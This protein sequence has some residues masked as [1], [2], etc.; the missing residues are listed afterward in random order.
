MLVEKM[1]LDDKKVYLKIDIAGAELE[2]IPDIIKYH[3]NLT[4]INLVIKYDNS[5]EIIK[6]EKLLREVEKNFILVARNELPGKQYCNC[7]YKNNYLS[8]VVSLTYINK[9]Y[10]DEKNIP[11]KQNYNEKKEY[12]QLYKLGDYMTKFD[13]NWILILSEKIKLLFGKIN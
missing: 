6:V 2:V 11:F 1:K 3:K 5:D 12:K 7:N 4:G 9:E 10:A 8:G 13:V